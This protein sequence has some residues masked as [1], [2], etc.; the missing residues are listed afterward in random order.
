MYEMGDAEYFYKRW[1]REFMN[2]GYSIQEAQR[3]AEQKVYGEGGYVDRL[4]RDILELEDRIKREMEEAKRE[5]DGERYEMLK[6]ELREL[7]GV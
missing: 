3:L 4:N 1:V 6:E 2:K 5:G 7:R